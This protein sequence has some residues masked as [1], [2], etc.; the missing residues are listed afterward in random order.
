M[1]NVNEVKSCY[2]L[3]SACLEIMHYVNALK[4]RKILEYFYKKALIMPLVKDHLNWS[5]LSSS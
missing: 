5:I 4:S 3:L 1:L 2:F